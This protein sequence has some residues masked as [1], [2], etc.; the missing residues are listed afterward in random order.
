MVGG[1]GVER[2]FS[3]ELGEGL[4]LRPAASDEVPQWARAE[5]EVSGDRRILEVAIIGGE[6]IE[7]VVAPA[8]VSNPLAKDYDLQ[9]QLPNFKP[10]LSFE[11]G[12]LRMHRQP[13]GLRGDR[14]PHPGPLA[15]GH[16]DGVKAAAAVQQFEDIFLEK[17]RIHAE[18]QNHRAANPRAQLI[19]QLAHEGL[20]SLGI[21]YVAGAVLM[22][23]SLPGLGLVPHVRIIVSCL[24]NTR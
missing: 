23:Q 22:P 19:D 1:N 15:K 18:F 3:L 14:S 4:F 17:R 12:D 21:L 9:L 24:A 7:L 20:R 16:L 10:Q 6:K 5:R 13:V 8:L 2:E 11:T